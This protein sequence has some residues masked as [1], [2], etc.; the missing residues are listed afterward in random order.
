MSVAS[1]LSPRELRVGA[2]AASGLGALLRSLGVADGTVMVVA[3]AGLVGIPALSLAIKG[4][5]A[6][7]LR[8]ELLATI[9]GEP[10]VAVADAVGARVREVSAVAVVGIGGGSAMDVAKV[11]A[12]LGTHAGPAR[13]LVG[14]DR[15]T[16][17]RLPLVL[18]PTT[19]GT[20]S[21]A[22]RIAMLSDGGGK[23][24]LSDARL[25]PDAAVLD[26]SFV[27]GLPPAVTASTG[28]DALAHAIE[29]T[30][31]TS[32]SALSLA[33]GA[34]AIEL[35][36]RWLPSAFHQGGL[37]EREA[38][39]IAAYSAGLALNA[40]VV[41][42]HSIAYTI[43]N[44]TGLPHGVTA[45]M[46]LPYCLAYNA[47]AAPGAVIEVTARFMGPTAEVRGDAEADAR[48]LCQAVGD[49]AADFDL[50]S[51]LAEVGIGRD[52]VTRMAAECMERY[53]RPTNP[54]P[55]TSDRLRVLYDHL[56]HGDAAGALE[57]LR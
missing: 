35:L 50:P 49:L 29:S 31:S 18:V 47:S 9:S 39:L 3:D 2:G 53:P 56:W 1:F 19:T 24:I 40:G 12:A 57:K 22:T 30:F 10:D 45:G 20:G 52:E 6:A 14:A 37:V 27:T 26:A 51:S 36:S 13:D 44:R 46:A 54:A 15:L 16:T 55:L 28:M 17:D 4:L 5:G 23:A 41:V 8:T 21:E 32:A 34:H 48:L 42:G 33:A 43:A 11:A 25:V 7:G 38:T